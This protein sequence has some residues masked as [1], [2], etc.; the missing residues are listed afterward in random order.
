M[1][2]TIK[3]LFTHTHP[4]THTHTH[5]FVRPLSHL[6]TNSLFWN[7]YIFSHVV[8]EWIYIIHYMFVPSRCDYTVK[9]ASKVFLFDN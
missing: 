1:G 7:M 5:I 3:S 8:G 9:L 2:V 4:H 6:C